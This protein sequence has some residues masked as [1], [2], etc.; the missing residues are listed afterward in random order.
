MDEG[1]SIETAQS[2]REGK[3]IKVT[4]NLKNFTQRA[5]F[6]LSTLV[7]AGAML[8]QTQSAAA[9]PVFTPGPLDIKSAPCVR[10]TDHRVEITR[11]PLSASWRYLAAPV[12]NV[13]ASNRTAGAGNDPQIVRYW[14]RY[15]DAY[16]GAVLSTAAGNV[17]GWTFGGES[18][19]NDNQMGSFVS[20]GTIFPESPTFS[21]PW[22]VGYFLD[23]PSA[24]RLQYL[25]AWYTTGNVYLGQ[26]TP[27]LALYQGGWG[28]NG[29][30]L[31]T[32][33]TH[34]CK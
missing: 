1:T 3:D 23:T 12:P 28:S 10:L 25:V 2:G 22:N 13:A 4:K 18:Q 16:T 5:R 27:G 33:D 24:V 7:I 34:V 26:A 21:R 29:F 31:Q 32:G 30:F 19:V 6:L 9:A 8:G 20:K 17:E 14:V 15:Y 11:N